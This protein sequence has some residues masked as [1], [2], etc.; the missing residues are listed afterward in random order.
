MSLAIFG[1]TNSGLNL[2]VTLF[3]LMLVVSGWR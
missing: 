3:V 1:I 2:V